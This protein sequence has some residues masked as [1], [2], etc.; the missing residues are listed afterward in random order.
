MS[1]LSSTWGV[2][3]LV[4][5][6]TSLKGTGS[7]SAQLQSFPNSGVSPTRE[8]TQLPAPR[9]SP[10]HWHLSWIP[11]RV[12]CPDLDSGVGSRVLTSRASMTREGSRQRTQRTGQTTRWTRTSI[13]S[14]IRSLELHRI[15]AHELLVIATTPEQYKEAAMGAATR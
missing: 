6:S 3:S 15:N 14:R 2:V 4:K 7:L 5:G 8:S 10:R 13:T 11:F 1:P 9:V 12:G